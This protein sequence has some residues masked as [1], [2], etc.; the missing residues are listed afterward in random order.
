[1]ACCAAFCINVDSVYYGSLSHTVNGHPFRDF[2]HVV[3]TL[4]DPTALATVRVLGDIVITP[5][6]NLLYNMNTENLSLHGIHPRYTHFAINMPL[7][8]GPLFIF[9]F[10]YIPNAIAKIRN[11]ANA[12]LFYGKNI[13]KCFRST[14]RS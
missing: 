2:G 12:H 9:G 5:L 14:K 13:Y 4:F 10:M 11:D 3:S 7:L 8:Y 6:N 1:M